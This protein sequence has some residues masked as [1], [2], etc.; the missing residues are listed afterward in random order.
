MQERLHDIL[1]SDKPHVSFELFPPKNNVGLRQIYQTIAKLKSMNPDFFSVTYGAGGSTSKKSL[2]IASAI[3]NLIDIT[4]VAHFTCV[5]MNREEVKKL[6]DSLEY[7]GIKSVL[8]LRGDKPKGEEEFVRPKDGF[9]YANELVSF[10]KE[11]SEVDI[12]VAGYPEGHNENPSKEDDFKNLLKKVDAGADGIVTQLFMDNQYLYEFQEK[13][14]QANVKVPLIAGIFP[15]SNGKQ[16]SRII[17]LSGCSVPESL[18]KGIEKYGESPKEME[19]FGTEFAINQVEEL[20]KH[21][22]NNFHFYTMNRHEQTR[23][24]LTALRAHFPHLNFD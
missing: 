4:C 22:V 2:E 15:I 21:G 3:I 5:G 23:A 6:L 7:Q 12:L 11:N 13:L 10:I 9:A 16:I 24:I 1:S 17:E 19:K 18:A 14:Q 8:A 20:L